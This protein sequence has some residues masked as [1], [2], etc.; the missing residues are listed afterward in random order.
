MEH[1][2]CS[3]SVYASYAAL[4]P[5]SA[6]DAGVSFPTTRCEQHVNSNTHFH[7]V[8]RLKTYGALPPNFIRHHSLLT[9]AQI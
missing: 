8:V 9:E 7:L 5:S 3:Q 1:R 2:L 4:T 6:Q